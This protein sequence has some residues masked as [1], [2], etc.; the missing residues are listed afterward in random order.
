M[1]FW[2]S[3]LLRSL[4]MAVVRRAA[5]PKH[6]PFCSSAAEHVDSYLLFDSMRLCQS[7]KWGMLSVL[8][9]RDDPA[10]EVRAE[11][12]RAATV[13]SF[14]MVLSGWIDRRAYPPARYRMG[15]AASCSHRYFAVA[16]RFRRPDGPP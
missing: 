10:Q 16:S 2:P 15:R 8:S 14:F 3:S 12:E 11:A 6:S 7:L 9:A 13:A 1:T 5:P 4:L